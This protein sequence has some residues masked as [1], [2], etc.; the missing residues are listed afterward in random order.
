M[1]SS[2]VERGR[3]AETMAAAFLALS[4]YRILERNVRFHHLEIDLIATIRNIL[5][6]VEVKYRKNERFGGAIRAVGAAKQRDL[7]TAAAGY[8]RSRRVKNMY[9]RF[10]VVAV[11]GKGDGSIMV[12]HVPGAFPA[13][14]RFR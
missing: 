8:L 7:E 11:E 13:S 10:D 3:H 12:R 9:I 4:G 2:H 5:A 6:I 1:H 14:A